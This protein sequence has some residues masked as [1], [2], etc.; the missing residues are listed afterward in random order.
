MRSGFLANG[1]IVAVGIGVTTAAL[2]APV[3]DAEVFVRRGIA[4][5]KDLKDRE[6]LDQF[7]RAYQLARTPRIAAQIGVAEQALGRWVDAEVH[8][9][10]ALAAPTDAWI[11]KNRPALEKAMTTIRSHLGSVEILGS[12][13][14]ANVRI[15]GREI[16]KVPLSSAL[17]VAAGTV[18]IEMRAPG[19]FPVSRTIS[20]AADVLTRETVV[21]PPSAAPIDTVGSGRSVNA[22]VSMPY[23]QAPRA[24][25]T[26]GST[27]PASAPIATSAEFQPSENHPSGDDGSRDLGLRDAEP[28]EAGS[29]RAP[30]AWTLT[31]GA[32][33]FAGG[34][35]AALIVRNGK[36]NDYNR[37]IDSTGCA[38]VAA[39]ACSQLRSDG[40]RAQALAIVGFGVAGAMAITAAILFVTAPSTP[41]AVSTALGA[42]GVDWPVRGLYCGAT[43]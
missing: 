4:L 40:D 41:A 26:G 8:V 33:A 16:G 15:D 14:G 22:S 42:C 3:D 30:L 25:P 5:R 35:V 37:S 1:W 10:Q 17:R 7:Q 19:H 27:G 24:T 32:V 2:A 39:A 18:V 20:V 43:F 34:G 31:A 11:V 36:A 6:A 12:P 13:A 23:D 21:L 28:R 9:T 38:G 29:W